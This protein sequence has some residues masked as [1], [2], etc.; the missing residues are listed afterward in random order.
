MQIAINKVHYPVTTLGYGKRVGIWT[1]GCSIRCPGCI[2]KDTWERSKEHW[3]QI[4]DLVAACRGWLAQ[5]DGITVS[6]GEPFDQPEALT[7]LLDRLRAETRG[8]ILVY[9]GY[10]HESLSKRFPGVIRKLDV[11]ITEP[12]AP[13]AGSSLFLRG[14]D[15]QKIFLLT[16]LARE[17][18]P[19]NINTLEWGTKS[20]LDI[21][22]EG[23]AIWMAGIPRENEMTKLKE[24]LERSGY[25]CDTS[26]VFHPLIRA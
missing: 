10:S 23:D 24:R 12:Y 3:T 6:G 9:S 22:M 4:D 26:D 14:S 1:Q 11:L 20:G 13:H 25:R 7:G 5:A 18:Y 15:N 8:D 16:P 2:S 19:S 21:M 17:R